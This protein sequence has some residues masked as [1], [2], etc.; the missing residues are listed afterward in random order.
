MHHCLVH[1]FIFIFKILTKQECKSQIKEQKQSYSVSLLGFEAEGKRKRQE[2]GGLP[3]HA[4]KASPDLFSQASL[5]RQR[6][7]LCFCTPRR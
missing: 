3:S 5:V 7:W 6:S 1:E 4:I 2:E